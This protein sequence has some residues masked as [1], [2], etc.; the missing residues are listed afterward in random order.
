MNKAD[1]PKPNIDLNG[2][3]EWTEEMVRGLLCNP[4]YAGI[5]PYPTIVDDATWVTVAAKSIRE[6]GAEQ[7]LVNLL[8]TLRTY[9]PLGPDAIPHPGTKTQQ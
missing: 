9:L 5:G 3:E 7:W 4:L 1:I 6:D 8:Y 2:G